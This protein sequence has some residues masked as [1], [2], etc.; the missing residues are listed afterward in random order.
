VENPTARVSITEVA[1]DPD[2]IEEW[3]KDDPV[4]R[5]GFIRQSVKHIARLIEAAPFVHKAKKRAT[6][7][8][9]AHK[10]AAERKKKAA[11]STAA[12]LIEQDPGLREP[13]KIE[14]VAKRT[15]DELIKNDDE[16]SA[17]RT[18]R[19]WIAEAKII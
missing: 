9:E 1:P 5:S 7:L 19:R 15:R 11:L 12:R 10:Q 2:Q 3:I 16:S 14:E 4:R 6:A 18:I 13:R 17:I 8:N